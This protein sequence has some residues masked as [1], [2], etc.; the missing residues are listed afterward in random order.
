M[1]N[2]ILASRDLWTLPKNIRIIDLQ[3]LGLMNL[4]LFDNVQK[5]FTS[6]LFHFEG[7][8]QFSKG[9][10]LK[11]QKNDFRNLKVFRASMRFHGIESL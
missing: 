2:E 1:S 5:I 6:V 3:T 8:T 10:N 9:R 11:R 7:T 4:D